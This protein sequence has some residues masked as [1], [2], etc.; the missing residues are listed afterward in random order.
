MEKEDKLVVF[1][2][3]KIRRVWHDDEWYFSVITLVQVLTDSDNPQNYR[4]ILK[5]RE[6]DAGIGLSTN[7]VHLKLEA[8]D[9]K[10]CY[11]KRI[12][13]IKMNKKEKISNFELLE[14]FRRMYLAVQ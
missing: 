9:G 10:L 12:A 8:P 3:K 13:Q 11:E 2:D 5:K 7:G 1:Q 14:K 4:S 6:F